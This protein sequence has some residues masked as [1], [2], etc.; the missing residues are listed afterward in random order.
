MYAIFNNALASKRFN[1]SFLTNFFNQ[2]SASI[3]NITT[4]LVG[5]IKTP[6]QW[7]SQHQLHL[8]HQKQIEIK[9]RLE[10]NS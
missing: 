3:A 9:G 2:V 10:T 4:I 8:A 7:L 5:Q 6:K 1:L